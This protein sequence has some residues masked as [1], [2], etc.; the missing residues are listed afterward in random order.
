MAA[1]TPPDLLQCQAERYNGANAFTVGGA[2]AYTRCKEN[3]VAIA[4]ETTVDED[5]D[6][7]SM[8]LCENCINA[9]L[10]QYGDDFA[11]LSPLPG[12][13]EEPEDMS[14]S[15]EVEAS[16]RKNAAALEPYQ[17][18]I[19][20]AMEFT[21]E[22]DHVAGERFH[23][24]TAM[25]KAGDDISTV[26]SRFSACSN[27]CSHCCH[28]ATTLS[29]EEAQFIGAMIGKEPLPVSGRED[30]DT[31][32]GKYRNVPCSFLDNGKCSIY[33]YRPVVCRTYFNISDH[34]ELCD[35]TNNPGA[36]VPALNLDKFW[37]LYAVAFVDGPMADIREFFPTGVRK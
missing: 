21:Q 37:A 33:A 4:T 3:P 14:F 7:G 10:T 16:I 32:V 23:I 35:L 22:L 24:V 25:Q 13:K 15:P 1:R 28:M 36:S 31:L 2:P 9:M 34:P 17:Y 26:V 8:S 19:K 29:E 11:V 30:R 27:G 12:T 18:L 5:G 20:Q 6:I